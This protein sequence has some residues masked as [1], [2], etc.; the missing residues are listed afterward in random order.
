MLARISQSVGRGGF[1][2]RNDALLVQK[3]LNKQTIPGAVGALRE[4]GIVGIKT[5]TRIELFQKHIVKMI[6]ADGRIDPNGKSFKLLCEV[7]AITP[8]LGSGSTRLLTLS[9][10]GL[11]L[12][13][14]IEDLAL[15]PYDDQTG[16]DITEWVKGA[17]IGYGH[18]IASA[19]WDKYKNSIS[20][21]SA[22]SLFSSD[23]APF[24]RSVQSKVTTSLKQN[25][26]DALVI[27]AFNIG[28]F[29]F[30][31]SSVLK[32][33]N[34]PTAIT[35]YSSLEAAWKAWNKSQGKEMRG[36]NNRRQAEWDIYSKNIYKQ[37]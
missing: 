14:A 22:S 2:I 27:F 7:K 18:L 5:I 3:L 11:S 28:D 25:E 20:E 16:K 13:K 21:A 24:I 6:R 35:S 17:T 26:F 4:D 32:L 36:L 29:N 34:D 37:W 8:Q 12:L 1:N 30:S 15:K 33:I 19:D 10:R 31:T 9:S 23:L